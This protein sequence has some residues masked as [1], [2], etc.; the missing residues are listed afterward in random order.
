MAVEQQAILVDKHIMDTPFDHLVLKYVDTLPK[1]ISATEV[2]KRRDL[3]H[4]L[5]LTIDPLTAKGKSKRNG[6]RA[7]FISLAFFCYVIDLDDALHIKRLDDGCFEVGVHI[8][9]VTH[10]V[11]QNSLLDS[12]AE[13]RGTNTYLTNRSIPMLP[14]ALSED[15]CS[16]TPHSDK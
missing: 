12:E 9:D 15:L 14:P 7:F 8:A 16:L 1:S 13:K 3:R 4:E 10:Y 5:V 11:K 2:A 6:N